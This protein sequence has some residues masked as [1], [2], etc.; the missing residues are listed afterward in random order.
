MSSTGRQS[1]SKGVRNAGAKLRHRRGDPHREEDRISAAPSLFP[2]LQG[3]SFPGAAVTSRHTRDSKQQK[4]VVSQ[5]GGQ[6]PQIQG[7]TGPPSLL[8]PQERVLP[9]CLSQ[10]LTAPAI[11]PLARG[12]SLQFLPFLRTAFPLCLG[13]LLRTLFTGLRTQPTS[14]RGFPSG[15]AGRESACNVGNG[16]GADSI[17]KMPW[18]GN[19]NHSSLLTWEIAWTEEELRIG[20]GSALPLA[21]DPPGLALAIP[22]PQCSAL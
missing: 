21:V 15:S 8:R 18:R 14:R 3:C 2:R 12:C 9:S 19:G 22:F 16:G 20:S 7:S 13:P 10:L 1:G 5:P 11:H 17:R 6:S 4:C